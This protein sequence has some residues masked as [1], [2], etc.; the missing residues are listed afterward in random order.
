M[1][2]INDTP[3][4]LSPKPMD[5]QKREEIAALK[6][7]PK[8]PPISERAK[9]LIARLQNGETIMLTRKGKDKWS[10]EKTGATVSAPMVRWLR[11][12]G[13]LV[14]HLGGLFADQPG[15]TWGAPRE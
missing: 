2:R 8:R 9:P 6:P 1:T 5:D 3:H 11:E 14:E 13:H 15:Q 4:S 7:K 10:W 12:N